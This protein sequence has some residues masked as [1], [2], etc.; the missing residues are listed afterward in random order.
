MSA[1]NHIVDDLSHLS[2]AGLVVIHPLGQRP[3]PMAH[4]ARHRVR[5]GET[6]LDEIRRAVGLD[7]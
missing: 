4:L 7:G 2:R 1:I 6:T 5:Q 3:R